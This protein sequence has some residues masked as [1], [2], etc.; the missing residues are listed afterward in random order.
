MTRA[1][2]AKDADKQ[3]TAK[4]NEITCRGVY[5]GYTGFFSIGNSLAVV[6]SCVDNSV[7]EYVDML[8]CN[9]NFSLRYLFIYFYLCRHFPYDGEL[10][11]SK[12]VSFV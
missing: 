4:E 8:S 1:L 2:N 12:N 7:I 10:F 11:N 6:L 9:F 5:H 3:H